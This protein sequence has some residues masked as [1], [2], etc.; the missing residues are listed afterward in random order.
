MNGA[1][2]FFAAAI[3]LIAAVAL[4]PAETRAQGGPQLQV[5]K[6][7]DA[8][9]NGLLDKGERV[10]AL[11]HLD[12]QP[13]RG[14]FGPRFGGAGSVSAGSPGVKLAPA[15]VAN[16][17]GSDLYDN[18][19][20]RTIFIDID[21]A[22]W[23]TELAAFYNTD[24]LLPATVTVDG[25]VYRDVGIRFRGNTSFSSVAAGLKR[26][27]QLKFDTVHDNQ[28]VEKYRTLN[29]L[30]GVNDPTGLRTF[31]Y[32]TI[33]RAYLPTPKVGLVRVVINGENW[34][35]YPNQQQFN[36]D[37]LR[38]FFGFS[39]GV[40][41]DVP[42]NMGGQGGMAYLGENLEAYRPYYEIDNQDRR[43]SWSAL[44][45][46]FRVLN[47]TPPEKLEA[48]LGP[49]LDIDGVLRFLAV[50]V[51]LA[52]TDGYWSRNSDYSIYLDPDGRFH[53]VAH[54][55]N[56]A[57]GVAGGRGASPTLDPLVN[58]TDTSKAL[59][60][61]L[62]AV[63]ALRQRYL[64]YVLDIATNWLDWGKL[65]AIARAQ[66]DLIDADVKRDTRKLFT[67][68]AFLAGF[69]SD[70]GSLKAF[71]TARREYLLAEVPKMIAAIAIK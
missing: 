29:L 11:A 21:A 6:Q 10:K 19:A 50:D 8:D 16:L 52:N 54:D 26:P 71:A 9:K 24:V 30:N 1:K 7:F 2:L 14:R 38:D 36:R 67:H 5:S 17:K 31:L 60:A 61:R 15:D 3:G 4:T 65:G 32:S 18:N 53:V 42:A 64:G 47:E 13:S 70:A 62:L 27:L 57:M 44:V 37:F 20:L 56:E 55:M 35:I 45:R 25:A 43:E 49:L 66:R 63:P 41:W 22:D 12:T 59:R 69:E 40:R 48:A 28:N 68:E 23:E 46:M 51:V 39:D 34:G 58:L 33:S